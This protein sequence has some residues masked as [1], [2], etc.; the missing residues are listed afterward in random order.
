MVERPIQIYV[1]KHNGHAATLVEHFLEQLKQG[2][3]AYKATS[4]PQLLKEALDQARPQQGRSRRSSRPEADMQSRH[5]PTAAAASG[6]TSWL[7]QGNLHGGLAVRQRLS[8][9]DLRGVSGWPQLSAEIQR[10]G[11]CMLLYL[12]SGMFGSKDLCDEMIAAL[13]VGYPIICV[14]PELSVSFNDVID[15][16]PLRLQQLGIFKT[17]AVPWRPVGSYEHVSMGLLAKLLGG[18]GSARRW[19]RDSVRSGLD[20]VSAGKD[21]EADS[22]HISLVDIPPSPFS[23]RFPSTLRWFRPS[24]RSARME[25][26]TDND[27]S[28][29][30]ELE[31]RPTASPEREDGRDGIRKENAA[32]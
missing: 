29:M 8:L 3:R 27:G 19:G 1:S 2:S 5:K 14:H 23:M 18:K 25:A 21:A 16:C 10:L 4:R 15:A 9:R 11:E 17:K 26:T 30:L 24:R 13:E 28:G 12:E 22:D 32:V 7:G 20:A 6:C 31:M